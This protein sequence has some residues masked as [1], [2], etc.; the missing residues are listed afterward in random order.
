[1]TSDLKRE[2]KLHDPK[3]IT[4]PHIPLVLNSND[5]LE[6]SQSWMEHRVWSAFLTVLHTDR[7]TKSFKQPAVN[8]YYRH[9][10]FTGEKTEAG[11][12]VLLTVAQPVIRKAREGTRLQLLGIYSQLLGNTRSYL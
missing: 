10:H 11:R 8:R 5:N 9:T 12:S 6:K 4:V 7:L 3:F 1:M 2:C